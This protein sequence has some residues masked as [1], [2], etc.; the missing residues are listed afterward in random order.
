MGKLWEQIREAV[1]RDQLAIS[2]HADERMR[3]R[4]IELW[5]LVAEVDEAIVVDE[6]PRSL[7]NPSVVVAQ[8][9]ADGT[10]VTVVWSWLENR[11][12]ARLV[13]IHLMQGST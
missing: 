4:R 7:P 6:R 10:P 9:L 12:L 5:Q 8:R 13:T 1:R 2:D 11:Q 3:E